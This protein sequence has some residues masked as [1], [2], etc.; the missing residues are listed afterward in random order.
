MAP[1]AIAFTAIAVDFN[2]P[3]EVAESDGAGRRTSA[4]ADAENKV[5]YTID[6]DNYPRT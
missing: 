6:T 2:E 4:K 3:T 1:S 5:D